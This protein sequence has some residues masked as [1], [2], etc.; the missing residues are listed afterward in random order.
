MRQT[1]FLRLLL[2]L[3]VAVILA[4]GGLLYIVSLDLAAT[5]P[6]VAHLRLPLYGAML[7][8]LAP[9][10]VAIKAVFDILALIDQGEAFSP[11]TVTLLRRLRMLVAVMAV[12]LTLGTVGVWIALLP[13]QSP[14]ILLGWF[15]G[16][17]ILLFL[18]TLGALFERLFTAALE[19]RQD[20]ELTV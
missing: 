8:G 9:V 19:L 20:N 2:V 18:L 14:S 10:V 5:Y 13:L 15:A 17:V 6:E 16:E 7:A 12:Y 3:L 11:C 4:A 1:W